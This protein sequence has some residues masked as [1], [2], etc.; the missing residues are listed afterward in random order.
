MHGG[1]TFRNK[2]DYL[3]FL[4]NR[5]IS[6]EARIRWA[7]AY[8][9][10]SLGKNFEII[11]PRMPQSDN[12]KYSEWKIHFERYI[13]FMRDNIILVGMSLGGIFLA[14]YLSENKFP[15]K[16]LSV[17]LVGAPFDDSLPDEDLVGGFRLKSN[18]SRLD[19][20][21]KNIFLMFSRDDKVV[22][23]SHAEKFRRKLKNA[24][25]I[26]YRSKGGHFKV[27]KFPELVRMIKKDIQVKKS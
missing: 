16:I 4:K 6:S 27:S 11:K 7:D 21:S 25:I 26:I 9:T 2:K 8:L 15:R 22:P 18:L 10:K 17:Y 24:K 12:A 19:N 1:M 23:L 14:K 3:H 20:C 13:P 5:E